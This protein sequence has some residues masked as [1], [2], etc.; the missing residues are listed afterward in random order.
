MM[1][2]L[3]LDN[4]E[5]VAPS[6]PLRPEGLICINQADTSCSQNNMI[7]EISKENAEAITISPALPVFPKAFDCTNQADTSYSKKNATTVENVNRVQRFERPQKSDCDVKQSGTFLR[8]G[9]A[10]SKRTEQEVQGQPIADIPFVAE[11]QT[12]IDSDQNGVEQF[13]KN[14]VSTK[15]ELTQKG[16]ISEVSGIDDLMAMT[17]KYEQYEDS[18]LDNTDEA[19]TCPQQYSSSR[20]HTSSVESRS[21][22]TGIALITSNRVKSENILNPFDEESSVSSSTSSSSSSSLSSSSSSSSVNS[23]SSSS[24]SSSSES[25]M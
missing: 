17:R 15:K 11:G 3:L 7:T 8:D 20:S 9:P 12:E 1:K 23:S 6:L 16:S 4:A 21:Q 13:G 19:N 2:K 24:S 22:D 10:P 5:T 18:L 14:G 25:S